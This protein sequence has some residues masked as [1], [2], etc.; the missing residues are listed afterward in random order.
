M[1]KKRIYIWL[2]SWQ[3]GIKKTPAEVWSNALN[4]SIYAPGLHISSLSNEF[5][6][7]IGEIRFLVST[8]IADDSQNAS[9]DSDP[10]DTSIDDISFEEENAGAEKVTFNLPYPNNFPLL[11]SLF[12]NHSRHG[13]MI[14]F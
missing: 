11:H 3:N 14:N 6:K 12:S 9:S 7:N 5:A 10:D 1:H 8:T 2:G 13:I 4:D